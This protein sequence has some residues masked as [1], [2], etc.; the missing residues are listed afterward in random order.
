MSA[1]A[2]N[3]FALPG[4]QDDRDAR[5]GVVAGERSLELVGDRVVQRVEALR[6]V[7]RDDRDAVARLGE[8]VL[9]GHGVACVGSGRR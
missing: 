4:D 2:A 7:E 3:A 1:P 5:V 9:V 6:A 8:E